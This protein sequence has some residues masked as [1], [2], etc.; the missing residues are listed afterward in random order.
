M[1]QL[2]LP[3]PGSVVDE[4]AAFYRACT[5]VI[6]QDPA[7]PRDRT[8]SIASLHGHIG[9]RTTQ[10]P[11]QT[12]LG[13]A[14]A[15]FVAAM[16]ERITATNAPW[17]VRELVNIVSLERFELA[18][19][20]QLAFEGEHHEVRAIVEPGAL[21]VFSP[22]VVANQHVFLAL[23]DERL[24]RAKSGVY[25][26][27]RGAARWALGYFDDLWNRAQ[28]QLRDQVGRREGEIADLRAAVQALES[29][30]SRGEARQGRIAKL[31][32]APQVD[33]GRDAP[34]LESLLEAGESSR[35]EYKASL[36]TSL[37]E[38]KV[39]KEL[40][41]AVVKTVAGFL[42]AD[43]GGTLLIGVDDV[44]RVVGLKNDFAS[45]GSIRGRDGFERHLYALLQSR[46]GTDAAPFVHVSFASDRNGTMVCRVD[47][48]PAPE[49][50]YDHAPSG[51]AFWLRMGNATKP[52]KIDE[53]IRYCRVRWP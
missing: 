51:D 22:L 50:V 38:G 34:D 37:D 1:V 39:M 44:G 9:R 19:S 35:L 5:A 6:R 18:S 32:G 11:T 10:E 25:L 16:S 8:I 42:N 53:A 30:R 17:H 2:R 20:R 12:E 3:A 28:W 4:Q 24:F 26:G 36:R 46:L 45:S 41:N 29:R 27:G 14:L 21:P 33:D 31:P 40:E 48:R 23:D 43:R 13:V 7:E 47:C 52:L 49:P 15:D